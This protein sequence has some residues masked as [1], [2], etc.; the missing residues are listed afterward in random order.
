[1][2]TA[3][4]FIPFTKKNAEYYLRNFKVGDNNDVRVLFVPTGRYYGQEFLSQYPDLRV[5]AS[6]TT[7][8]GHID[9][10]YCDKHGEHAADEPYPVCG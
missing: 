10:E 4:N 5:V 9:T 3:R 8:N 6:N 2:L 1:M 7:G